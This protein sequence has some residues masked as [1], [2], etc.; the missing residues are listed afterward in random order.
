[1]TLGSQIGVVRHTF[2]NTNH[3][4]DKVQL[5]V[6]IDFTSATDSEVKAWATASR[7]ITFQKPLSKLDLAGMKALDGATFQAS[8]IGLKIK[9]A[10]ERM[11]EALYLRAKSKGPEAIA[12]LNAMLDAEDAP[13]V[14]DEDDSE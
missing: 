14:E 12:R 7:T 4:G 9:T 5:T 13:E 11:L 6:G 1:M 3:A 2:S 8:T 10:E